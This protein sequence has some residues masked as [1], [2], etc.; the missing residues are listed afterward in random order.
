[1]YVWY[2]WDT[3]INILTYGDHLLKLLIELLGNNHPSSWHMNFEAFESPKLCP[4]NLADTQ[5]L[6]KVD[7]QALATKIGVLL[8]W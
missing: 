6:V 3:H 8:S 1:M 4:L 5:T 2:T 7:I